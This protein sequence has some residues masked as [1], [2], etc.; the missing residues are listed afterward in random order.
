VNKIFWE[1]SNSLLERVRLPNLNGSRILLTGATGLIGRNILNFLQVILES[2][3]ST[4]DVDAL[5]M[6]PIEESTKYHQRIRFQSGNL[7]R[8]LHQFDL[9]TYDYIIHAATYGQPSK[10]I[11][12]STETMALN[13]PIVIEITKFLQPN[14]TFLYL[15][16]SE[17]YS[18]SSQNP[19]NEDDLGALPFDSDRA[20]YVYGKTFGEVSLMQ[21]REEHS[22]RIGRIA[23]SYGPGTKKSDSRVLNQLI[24][25]G[26]LQGEVTLGDAGNAIRTYCYVSDTVE[27]LMNIAFWGKSEVYN[28]GG[29]SKVTIRELG[30]NI[31][32]ILGVKFSF[33]ET[34]SEYL[35]S[36][37]QVELDISKFENEFGAMDFAPLHQGL[38]RTIEWQRT[39]LFKV[40]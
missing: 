6:S 32:S 12:K 38:L 25:R 10:F 30:K 15:S 4:F 20:P 8:G 16:S 31:A 2:Q 35:D 21:L 36:P 11:S 27:M 28:V 33:P 26:I 29:V 19:N 39:E 34:V 24:R 23:L 14:G 37:K 40:E 18:G 5:S 3:K 1:D 17:I 9:R 22:I 13:G 7:S